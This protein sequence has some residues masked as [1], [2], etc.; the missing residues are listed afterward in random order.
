MID[1]YDRHA[2]LGLHPWWCPCPIPR[3]LQVT[4]NS[5]LEITWFCC[6]V[7]SFSCTKLP[8]LSM[9][10]GICHWVIFWDVALLSMSASRYQVAWSM[11]ISIPSLRELY[12]AE[13]WPALG[14]LA[15]WEYLNG[16]KQAVQGEGVI[17]WWA[18]Q[19]KCSPNLTIMFTMTIWPF[20][21]SLG[22]RCVTVSRVLRVQRVIAEC[23]L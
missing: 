6:W 17:W 16:L 11:M 23:P 19:W 7:S 9:C 8:T 4:R 1:Q 13:A 5:Q 10:W 21:A 14:W 15:Q 3:N 12:G 2:Y 22:E 20:R 18:V